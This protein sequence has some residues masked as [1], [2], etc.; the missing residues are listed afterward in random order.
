MQENLKNENKGE[1]TFF[2]SLKRRIKGGLK[3][4]DPA[5]KGL[6]I[7]EGMVEHRGVGGWVADLV[8]IA[9]LL[10]CVLIC[11]VPMWHT[12]MSSLS[13]GF[14]LFANHGI[15]WWP[16]G[17]ANLDGYEYIFTAEQYQIG[18]GYLNTIIY[19]VFGTLLGF[20]MNIVSGY[21]L[22]R[23]TKLKSPIIIFFLIATMFSGGTVPTYLV[24]QALG[25]TE[26]ALS[27][28]I[29]GATNAIFIILAMN[30][31]LQVPESTIEAAKLDGAGPLRIMFKVALPQGLGLILVTV[32]NTA[33]GVWN[34]WFTAMLYVPNQPDLW[35]LQLWIQKVVSDSANYI[36]S[37]NPDYVMETLQ[38]VVVI[39]SIVPIYIAF[40]FFIKKLEKGMVLG[41]VKE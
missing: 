33:V 21:I 22:S 11:I 8:M 24:I 12:L 13:D 32:I 25:L 10:L 17:D 14:S 36:T 41:A 31:F 1:G 20:V 2:S 3:K 5:L 4:K 40:P 7:K 27:L 6:R 26:T 29:P 19:V 18:R 37:S 15:V 23:K 16:V 34:S 30:S 35:P 38:Y 9:F 28:I 39:I